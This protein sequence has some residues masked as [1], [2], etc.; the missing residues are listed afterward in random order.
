M[1]KLLVPLAVSLLLALAIPAAFA[2]SGIELGLSWTST[3]FLQN[4]GSG[5]SDS[6][7]G[8]HGAYNWL[9]LTGSVDSLA[10]PA[11]MMDGMTGVSVPGF[12]N[13]F[14]AGLKLRLRPFEIAAEVGTNYV[15]FYQG[16]GP[17]NGSWGANLRLLAG[18]NFGWWGVGVS[19]TS[20]FDTFDTMI[21][22]IKGL[23]S[24]DT[25]TKAISS[26]TSGLV[27]SIYVTFY[28]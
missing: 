5:N 27:P 6:I 11:S 24:T 28:F 17:S 15:Y 26:L 21:S 8:F 22:T 4:Q 13:L 7:L 10:L 3:S 2:D 23:F 1:K 19:G 9:I 12:L 25:R 20:A 18:L 16:L 14:D